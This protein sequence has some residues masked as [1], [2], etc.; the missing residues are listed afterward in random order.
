MTTET[1]PAPDGA[2]APPPMPARFQTIVADPPWPVST[3][4]NGKYMEYP[5]M[6]YDWIKAGDRKSVV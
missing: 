4:G 5:L 1:E 2:Q 6:P 3:V